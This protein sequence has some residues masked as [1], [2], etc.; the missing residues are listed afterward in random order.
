M[1][2]VLRCCGALRVRLV[3]QVDGPVIVRDQRAH[4]A[5]PHR[6]ALLQLHCQPAGAVRALC[7]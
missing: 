4:H 2:M 1:T 5:L 6:C 7:L 3:T